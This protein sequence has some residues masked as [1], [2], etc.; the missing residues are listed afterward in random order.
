MKHAMPVIPA[1]CL[2]FMLAGFAATGASAAGISDLVSTCEDCHGK[3]GAS[4]NNEIPIIGG[5]SAQY[6]IDS[7]AAYKAR[8]RPCEEEKYLSGP[9][10]GEAGDMCKVTEKLSD[11]DIKQV[12][13]HF[14][15]LPFVRAKQGF[16]AGLA[17]K[18]KGI[19]NL[20]CVKC[21]DAGG[22]SPED[23][24]GILAGQWRPYLQKQFDAF[25]SGKREMS[26]KMKVKMDKISRE[27]I[28][29]LLHYFSSFQ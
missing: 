24:A 4:M 12:A 11:A 26:K 20:Q 25:G 28:D 14:A 9:H 16:D 10:K 5:F 17:N 18:G 13:E 2:G 29:A 27:D 22:S 3:D 19:Q 1:L 15:A 21:H 6:I 8:S 7:F 23:D